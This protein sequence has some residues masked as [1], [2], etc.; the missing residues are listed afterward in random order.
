M[1]VFV[2]RRK[3]APNILVPTTTPWTAQCPVHMCIASPTEYIPCPCSPCA[4]VR[5]N[6]PKP[7]PEFWS[8]IN[9]PAEIMQTCN[10][11][12]LVSQSKWSVADIL[13][14]LLLQWYQRCTNSKSVLYMGSDDNDGDIVCVGEAMH[15]NEMQALIAAPQM[16]DACI[17]Y[18]LH[19]NTWFLFNKQICTK[20]LAEA[21][22]HNAIIMTEMV[23]IM[24]A[25]LQKARM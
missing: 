21:S 22:R 20:V 17:V 15:T 14:A 24:D 3:I 16:T 9:D 18:A 11:L 6:T 2:E 5:S 25:F 23:A 12:A 7:I 10:D 1:P 4:R 13:A 19:N 8:C